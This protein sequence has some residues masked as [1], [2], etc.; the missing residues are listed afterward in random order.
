MP[1]LSESRDA[2]LQQLEQS[3]QAA[4]GL[5]AGVS[6]KQLNWQPNGGKSWSIWQC[7]DH[8]AKTDRFYCQAMLEAIAHSKSGM[9]A[10]GIISPGLFS[11]WFI[12][13]L[14]PTSKAKFKAF[15]KIAPGPNGDAQTALREFAES[16]E[17]ARRVISA[18]EVR[19]F[20]RV[21]FQNPFV[22]I[23]R[24]TIGTGLMIINAHD[25]RHLSQAARVKDSDSYPAA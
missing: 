24:F 19:D 1:A 16:H 11:R 6:A 8:I 20:N 13:S 18:W 4:I 5:I 10:T 2:I 3:E 17:Q 12:A 21:R 7:L 22:P 15:D 9:A 14:E 23:I 25:R